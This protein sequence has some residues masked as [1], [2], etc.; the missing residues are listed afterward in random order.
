MPDDIDDATWNDLFSWREVLTKRDEAVGVKKYVAKEDRVIRNAEA[1]EPS[2]GPLSQLPGKWSNIRPDDD[3]DDP[4]HSPLAGRGW[5]IIALPFASEKAIDPFRAGEVPPYRVLMNRYNEELTFSTVDDDVPNRGITQDRKQRADQ[6]VAALDYEQKIVQMAAADVPK[7]GDAGGKKLPIHHEPGLFLYMQVQ[8]IDG[9]DICRL[10]TIP[11]GNAVNAI[12]LSS[13][14]KDGPPQIPNLSAFP[15][16]VTDNIVSAVNEADATSAT[17]RN[18]YLFPYKHFVDE[19]FL[20]LF[21][22]ANTNALLQQGL[23]GNVLKTTVLDFTTDVAEA[24]IVNVPF[25]ERQADASQMR[26][27][28]WLMELDEPALGGM[29]G[30]RLVLAYSQFI[31]LDFFPRFDGKPGLIRWPHVSINMMEKVAPPPSNPAI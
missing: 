16:G 19:P 4:E 17:P 21:S 27:T 31:N 25:I 9:F 7:S 26:S 18:R 1:V 13:P 8:V 29:E 28:F 20:N 10:G 22:P 14:T 3:P 30:N 2:L 12:G 11:H 5:N 24:G 6:L 15:E 23:P